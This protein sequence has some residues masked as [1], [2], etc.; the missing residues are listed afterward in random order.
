[1]DPAESIARLSEVEMPE[2]GSLDGDWLV[3]V[4]LDQRRDRRDDVAILVIR[5]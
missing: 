3:D 1:V 5:W 2:P 4:L